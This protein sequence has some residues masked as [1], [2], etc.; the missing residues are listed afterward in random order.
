MPICMPLRGSCSIPAARQ[1]R[2]P[3]GSLYPFPGKAR[4]ELQAGV[5]NSAWAARAPSI[6]ALRIPPAYPAPSPTG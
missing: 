6:A 1:Y 3:G 4:S 2:S 5:R